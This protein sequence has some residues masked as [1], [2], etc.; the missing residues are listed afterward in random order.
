MRTPGMRFCPLLTTQVY[1]AGQ[2]GCSEVSR[3]SCSW[4]GEARAL[5]LRTGRDDGLRA[6][7]GETETSEV[8]AGLER[9]GRDP[10]HP[11]ASMRSR[12]RRMEVA[13]SA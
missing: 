5:Q 1:G 12:G 9:A 11:S 2:Q 6:G 10:L 4:R 7:R 13:G 8:V 3:S